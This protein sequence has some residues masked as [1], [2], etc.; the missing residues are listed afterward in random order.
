MRLL[1]LFGSLLVAAT[2]AAQAQKASGV[3]DFVSVDTP[4]FVLNHVRVIDGTGAPAREDQAI[5]IANGRIQSI[6][7][8]ASAQFLRVRRGWSAPATRSYL[9]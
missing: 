9:V 1:L 4:V 5:V 7:P 2:A 6:G 3:A 8:A